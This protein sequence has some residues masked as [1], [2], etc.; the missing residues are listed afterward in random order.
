MSGFDLPEHDDASA[1]PIEAHHFNWLA[2]FLHIKPASKIL[3]FQVGRGRARQEL[4]RL[5]RD[6]GKPF[7]IRDVQFDR[8]TNVVTARV[9]RSNR[10]F[11]S[12]H[13]FFSPPSTFLRSAGCANG[14][15]QDSRPNLWLL[16]RSCL[17]CLSMAAARICAS[18]ASRRRGERL[19]RSG[20]CWS[21][22]KRGLGIWGC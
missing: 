3:C 11:L 7:G 20:R 21:C 17:L 12:L 8:M 2:R 22:W 9:N 13:L 19:A 6:K 16:R 10:E 15:V 18:R 1:R 14:G 4:V 5:L